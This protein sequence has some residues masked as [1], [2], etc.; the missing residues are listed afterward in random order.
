MASEDD[1][2]PKLG[3]LRSQT[4]KLSKSYRSKVLHAVQRAGGRKAGRTGHGTNPGYGRGAGAARVLAGIPGRGR[5]TRRVT[6]KARFVKL[7]GPGFRAAKAHLSYLQRD[8]VTRDGQPGQL[9]GPETDRADASEFM[10][11]C[12][13]DRHQFRFIVSPED[14]LQY[15]DLKP[16]TRKVMRQME[17]DLGT[18]LEWTA[19]DHYNTGRPHTHIVIRGRDD[20]GKDLVIAPE[21]LSAGFRERVAAQITLDLGPRSEREILMAR[22]AEIDAER[23]TSIDRQLRREADSAGVVLPSHRPPVEHAL[24]TGRLVKLEA[25]GLAEKAS[26][27]QWRLHPDMEATLRQMSELGDIIKTLH[28]A[29]KDKGL[30]AA[31]PDAQ[32]HLSGATVVGLTGKLRGRLVERGLQE[33]FSDRHYLVLEGTDGR[34]HYIDIGSGSQ[35]VLLPEGAILE[36]TPRVPAVREV[37][38]A[39][40]AV[41]EVS[42]GYYSVDLHLKADPSARQAFAETHS[43][44]LE[45][46]RR[47]TGQIERLPDGRFRIDSHHLEKAMAYE[48]KEAARS[49]VS[50]AVVA[51]QTLE[52]QQRFNG[53][54]W[55]DKEWVAGDHG[56]FAK[57]GFGGEAWAAMQARQQWLVE[58]GLWTPASGDP[59]ALAPSVLNV[60]HRRELRGL[61]ARLE[62]ETGKAFRVV[63]TGA[64]VEGRLREIV[65]MGS[66]KFA[67]V[68]RAK[69]FA[70]VPWRPVL[71]KHIGK[72]V[73]G[74][75]R[76]TG[77]NWRIG[78]DL[79]RDID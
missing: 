39:V 25:L 6:V 17:T 76:E 9:Y 55:L 40:M 7:A 34:A 57:T 71:E 64:Q 60:L 18:S 36:I 70:L 14:G 26:A 78:R 8:G 41:A 28:R 4:P 10:A 43:R 37:D 15:D 24:R 56:A 23:L 47:T 77:I 1:F 11:R 2:E 44:R 62:V 65:E 50:V 53:V 31:V 68:E 21:Y 27:G 22:Q 32:T 46:I 52:R 54:T 5:Q 74:M 30:E 58:E 51:S 73:S 16:L 29:L 13:G 72:E 12:E 79:G 20:K 33:E 63:G 19:V 49:P 42:G 59:A 45:A 75:V 35:T 66:G 67:V 48:Q 61:S 69:D 38:R 3:K